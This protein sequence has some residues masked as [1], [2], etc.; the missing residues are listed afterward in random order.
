MARSI[1]TGAMATAAR[2]QLAVLAATILALFGA[3]AQAECRA[4]AAC[5]A[6][7]AA[8]GHPSQA[9]LEAMAPASC[10]LGDFTRA[11][12][13]TTP[14]F[15]HRTA[16][17]ADG[18]VLLT[19]G[20]TANAPAAVI[21]N[22]VDIFNPADNTV[23]P[24]PPMTVKRWS[25]TATTLADGRVLV[26]GGRTG[27]TAANGVVLATAEIY[28]P[29][30]NTWTETASPMNVARRSHTA[31]LMQDGRVLVAGGGNGVV[32]TTSAAIQSAEI[33]DPAAGTFTLIGDMI[34]KRSA[35]SA[36]LMAGGT[37]LITGGS[38]GNGTLFPTTAAEIFNPV[39]NTF[40]SVGPMNFPHLAQNPGQLRDGRLIQPSSY[41]NNTH[42]SAG[43]VIT[44]ES[45]IYNPATQLFTPI[46]PMFK[47]RI[48]IGAIGLL[49]GSLLVAGGVTTS[50]SYPSIFQSSSEVY[51]PANGHW[52][53]SGIMS[54]GRD[55]FSGLLLNDGR[56][57]ISGGFVSP[58]AVLLNSVEIYTPGLIPQVNG[59]R[60]VLTDLP[61]SVYR[62]GASSRLQMITRI[63]SIGYDVGVY[64]TSVNLSHALGLARQL[65]AAID[66]NLKP[67]AVAE[68]TRLKSISQVLINTLTDKIS[69]NL[70]PTVAPVAAPNAGVESLAVN[71]ASNAI[72]GDGSIVSTQWNFGDF[73]YSNAA[74]PTH[75]YQCDGNYTA[76]V[77]VVDNRGAVASGTA[78]ITVTSAGGPLTHACD[79][80]PI[81]N[82]VCTGCHGSA[83]GLSLTTCEN[84]QLGS[85]PSPRPVV[86]PGD[87]ANSRLV[88]RINSTT[89]PMPPIGGQL[90]AAEIAAITDW[91]N[92]LNP[93]DTNFCD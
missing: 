21:T 51:N 22:S 16:K 55:E 52:N 83:R 29:A 92:S 11:L 40:T 67:A 63:T 1:L 26:T 53:V 36:T 8:I 87:A 78:S 4:P 12:N 37:I 46:E 90:P 30:T 69:P 65:P 88:Q 32:T 60:N 93:A 73:T 38:A 33:F 86:I 81:F 6:C 82:R 14:R 18:R 58:G 75:T 5:I 66:S 28:D 48:D 91:I 7:H 17:L 25:H 72:D 50:P 85:S 70:G 68:K 39:G 84:L 44:A 79:V 62:L 77:D 34:T 89:A 9:V 2:P 64:G 59:F 10:E 15:I 31:T 27:S 56:A 54:S 43:G 76:T 35:H 42:T 49:D 71:F 41:Y 57:M 13:M 24:G 3:Q 45:E 19:G 74:N 20:E 80:Q 61:A 23:T 47:K